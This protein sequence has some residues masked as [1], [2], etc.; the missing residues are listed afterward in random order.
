MLHNKNALNLINKYQSSND[1][2]EN[3]AINAN[4][5]EK[6]RI[7]VSA[8]FDISNFRNIKNQS[9][10]ITSDLCFVSGANASGKTSFLEAIYFLAFGKSFRCSNSRKIIHFDAEEFVVH[11][12]LTQSCSSLA[13]IQ[14]SHNNYE[15]S[16]SLGLLKNKA[17]EMQLRVNN[18]NVTS[19]VALA[20][21]FPVQLLNNDSYLLLEGEPAFRRKFLDWIL[22]HVEPEFMDV[23]QSFKRVLMQRNAILKM[24]LVGQEL[25]AALG[26]WD[27]EFCRY[28]MLMQSYRINVVAL[29]QAKLDYLLQ[30]SVWGFDLASIEGF[31]FILKYRTN[32]NSAEEL[33]SAL[34]SAR[35][36]DVK[37]KTTTVG[38]HRDD[39]NIGA[40]GAPVKF[41]LSRGQTKLLV[42]ALNIARE[43]LL[44]DATNSKSIFLIDDLRA[45]FDAKA[46]NLVLE[47]LSTLNIKSIVTGVEP[48]GVELASKFNAQMFHVERGVFR[49]LEL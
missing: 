24:G 49:E 4:S 33:L 2:S 14:Q 8:E 1:E 11:A 16:H 47:L 46:F 6:T 23:W 9:L 48:L 22:F 32:F 44:R 17:G 26:F 10:K 41:L 19:I 18:N 45:E 39:I 27:R 36:T 37:A 42:F 38:P 30:D 5:A 40:N 29:L 12:K 35:D 13:A 28:A 3:A 20:K 31:N 15:N 21:H 25:D 34:L 7:N 43:L